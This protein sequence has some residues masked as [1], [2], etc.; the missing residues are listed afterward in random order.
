[1]SHASPHQEQMGAGFL[2][3]RVKIPAFCLGGRRNPQKVLIRK[4]QKD[5]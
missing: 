3:F 4:M 1:M 2:S 5:I